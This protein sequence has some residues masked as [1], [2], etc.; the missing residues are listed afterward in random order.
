MYLCTR[1]RSFDLRQ[2]VTNMGI[3]LVSKSLPI[4][5]KIFVNHSFLMGKNIDYVLLCVLSNSF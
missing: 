2:K 3:L 5:K 4:K 1:K